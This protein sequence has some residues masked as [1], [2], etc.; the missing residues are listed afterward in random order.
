VLEVT[1]D[2]G[3]SVEPLLHEWEKDSSETAALRP[4]RFIRH[5]L[6]PHD[7]SPDAG[8][9]QAID[10]WITGPAP[11]RILA[12]ALASARTPE[13]AAILSDALKILGSWNS[14]P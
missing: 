7:S 14:V 11:Q 5:D 6:S 8:W 13:V 1:A 12:A 4:A 2:L 9:E 10:L 3:M